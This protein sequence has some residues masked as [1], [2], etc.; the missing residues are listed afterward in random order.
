M[1]DHIH[2]ELRDW[3]QSTASAG[4]ATSVLNAV[5]TLRGDFRRLLRSGASL[6]EARR[7]L[8]ASLAFDEVVDNLLFRYFLTA[9]N[10]VLFS[11]Y[12]GTSSHGQAG[13]H[14]VFLLSYRDSARLTLVRQGNDDLIGPPAT[15]VPA[16][17]ENEAAERLRAWTEGIWC[18]Q[19]PAV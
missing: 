16:R 12:A 9:P 2:P 6:P 14:L 11:L 17:L 1:L 5:H 4:V 19:V 13:P 10:F 7:N 8:K 3:L 15:S 18:C